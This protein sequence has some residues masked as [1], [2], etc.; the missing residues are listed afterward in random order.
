MNLK[1]VMMLLT[2]VGIFS[3]TMV[4]A[5]DNVIERKWDESTGI[6]KIYF[7]YTGATADVALSHERRLGNLG[8]DVLGLFSADDDDG[9]ERRNEQ[10]HLSSS[11]LYHVVDK[12]RVMSMSVQV[13]RPFFT[14]ILVLAMMKQNL[15]W[16]PFLKWVPLII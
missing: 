1:N 10:F 4:Q 3:L 12:S 13:F 14:M 15:R 2:I 16:V 8:W 9:I 7:G 6:S 11:L 5:Q